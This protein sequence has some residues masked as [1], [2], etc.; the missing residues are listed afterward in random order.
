M[1][2]EHRT[3]SIPPLMVDEFIQRFGEIPVKLFAKHGAKTVGVWLTD[4][5]P[6]PEVVYIL[7]FE[8]LAHRD[9]FWQ[10]LFQDSEFQES[11][12]S[13]RVA[14]FNAKILRPLPYSPLQ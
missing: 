12:Q 11:K 5:G 6:G 8:D 10:A 14:S 7:A 13:T 4:V 3:Y 2:Y 9:R 1:I